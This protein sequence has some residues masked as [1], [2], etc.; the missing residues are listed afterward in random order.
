MQPYIW[1]YRWPLAIGLILLIDTLQGT[2]KTVEDVERA[3]PVP[4][5]G[6]LSHLETIEERSRQVSGRRRASM[7]AAA[8]LLCGVVVVTVYY[9]A[10]ERL[11]PFA[12]DLLTMVLGD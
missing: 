6:G 7:V 3:L 12:R 1:P 10:P 8:L 2:L 9:V 4:V 11:P 5:L